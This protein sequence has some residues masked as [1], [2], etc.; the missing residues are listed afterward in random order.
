MPV[1]AFTTP[2]A[3]HGVAAVGLGIKGLLLLGLALGLGVLAKGPVIWLHV[4]P[5]ALLAPWWNP[6]LLRAGW[7]GRLFAAF[8]IGS[9]PSVIAASRWR[10]SMRLPRGNS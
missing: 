6:E 7:Y 8:L 3:P 9:P 1:A 4:L 2:H 5:A 10:C